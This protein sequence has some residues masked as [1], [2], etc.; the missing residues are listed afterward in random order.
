MVAIYWVN[1]EFPKPP[2]VKLMW[3]ERFE[4]GNLSL[5]FSPLIMILT[6]SKIKEDPG[7]RREGK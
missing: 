7:G 3:T 4:G 5:C 6:G 2:I 1:L